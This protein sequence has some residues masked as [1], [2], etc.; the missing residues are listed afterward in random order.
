MKDIQ[1]NALMKMEQRLASTS[2]N[3]NAH[4]PLSD[5]SSLQLDTNTHL[6]AQF[7]KNIPNI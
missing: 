2:E 1:Q 3:Q 7:E 5:I 6:T 4:V